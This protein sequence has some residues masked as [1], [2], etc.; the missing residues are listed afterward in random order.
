MA[1]VPPIPQ[2]FA[3]RFAGMC[4]AVAAHEGI[5]IREIQW[6]MELWPAAVGVFLL[7]RY[8]QEGLDG[9]RGAHRLLDLLKNLECTIHGLSWLA[10]QTH[11]GVRGSRGTGRD[12]D[13]ILPVSALQLDREALARLL[14]HKLSIDQRTRAIVQ[15][16]PGVPAVQARGRRSLP[17]TGAYRRAAED[18]SDHDTPDSSGGTG[19]SK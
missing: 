6:R 1:A 5:P 14:K 2:Q 3:D 16:R 9:F 18:V 10:K 8:E 4:E 11:V 15:V 17:S 13:L 19:T 7:L 12:F